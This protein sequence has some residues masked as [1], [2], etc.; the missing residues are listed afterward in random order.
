MRAIRALLFNKQR[1][2]VFFRPIIPVL[3]QMIDFTSDFDAE[4]LG[5]DSKYIKIGF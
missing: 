2:Y 4:A 5:K 1:D 3:R